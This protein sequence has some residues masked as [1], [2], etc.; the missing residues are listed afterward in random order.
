M[1]YIGSQDALNSY[2]PPLENEPNNDYT[3]H[4]LNFFI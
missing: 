1:L 4:E 2:Y 3:R